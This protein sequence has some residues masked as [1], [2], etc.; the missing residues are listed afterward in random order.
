MI[1]AALREVSKSFDGRQVL[2][3]L[4]TDGAGRGEAC[5]VWPLRMRE[6]DSSSSS[7]RPGGA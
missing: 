7:C 1:A 4:L 3:G 2:K 5:S 6:N